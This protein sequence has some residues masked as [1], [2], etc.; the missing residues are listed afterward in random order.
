MELPDFDYINDTT[1][2][3]VLEE[4]D[5]GDFTVTPVDYLSASIENGPYI[6]AV[7]GA[8][9][10]DANNTVWVTPEIAE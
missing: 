7:R 4:V 2:F 10:F 5:L 6:E 9:T 8:F 1:E 3:I